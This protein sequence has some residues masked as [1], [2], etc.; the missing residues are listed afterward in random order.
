M[1]RLNILTWYCRW[2]KK[3]NFFPDVLLSIVTKCDKTKIKCSFPIKQRC[4]Y[5]QQFKWPVHN[6]DSKN[7]V[8]NYRSISLLT[9]FDKIFEKI[10]HDAL[11]DYFNYNQILNNSQSG[12]RKDDSFVAQLLV[13]V[14]YIHIILNN[15]PSPLL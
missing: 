4:M 9:S 11:Y 10:F 7:V 8:R 3:Y 1:P 12:Y 2:G 14:H 15:T 5:C 6:K 13:I